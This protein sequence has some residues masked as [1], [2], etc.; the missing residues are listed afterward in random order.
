MQLCGN[1]LAAIQFRPRGSFSVDSVQEFIC[2]HR[3]SQQWIDRCLPLPT[4]IK[5]FEPTKPR[6][7]FANSWICFIEKPCLKFGLYPVAISLAM[8]AIRDRQWQK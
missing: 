2:N 6:E 7:G 4:N 5:H 3:Y 1:G 8:L